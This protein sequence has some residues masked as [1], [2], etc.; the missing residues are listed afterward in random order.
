MRGEIFVFNVTRLEDADTGVT[1]YGF[2]FFFAFK[3]SW[4]FGLICLSLSYVLADSLGFATTPELAPGGSL[5]QDYVSSRHF[6]L[7]T[8]DNYFLFSVTDSTLAEGRLYQID[9]GAASV[10][11]YSRLLTTD[12]NSGVGFYK[13]SN[14]HGRL[15]LALSNLTW[16][17]YDRSAANVTYETCLTQINHRLLLLN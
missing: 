1:P 12:T 7:L 17:E 10:G 8:D 13:L 2:F 16:I 9:A 6:G 3:S 5:G 4:K 11:Q 14:F 15:Y